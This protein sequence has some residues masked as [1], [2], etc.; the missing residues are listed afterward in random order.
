MNNYILESLMIRHMFEKVCGCLMVEGK[1]YCTAQHHSQRNF[2][3]C[4]E[5]SFLALSVCLASTEFLAV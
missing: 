3:N 5:H 2:G 1:F 4:Q